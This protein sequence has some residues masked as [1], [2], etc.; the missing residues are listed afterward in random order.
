MKRVLIAGIVFLFS[1][2]SSPATDC[3][4][5]W[6]DFPKVKPSTPGAQTQVDVCLSNNFGSHQGLMQDATE[7]AVAQWN[8]TQQGGMHAP[9]S[10][11]LSSGNC[12]I[13][14]L[15][16]LMPTGLDGIG[17]ANLESDLI[18]ITGGVLDDIANANIDEE[19]KTGHTASLVAHELGHFLG[20][21]NLVDDPNCAQIISVMA[22]LAYWTS[23]PEVVG[24]F[25]VGQAN[26]AFSQTQDSD[27]AKSYTDGDQGTQGACQEDPCGSIECSEFDESCIDLELDVIV[28]EAA[29][30]PWF[31][32]YARYLVTD[33]YSCSGS[34]CTYLYTQF[35][36]MGIVCY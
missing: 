23:V 6:K 21:A 31:G 24:A 12:D 15:Q 32:C 11:N 10:F 26:K 35:E 16:G 25:D 22:F 28:E 30:Y 33:Y 7:S 9:Y 36:F 20:L 8:T 18:R 19:D 13:S 5:C 14:I 2:F 17:Y 4:P 34:G 1:V 29:P 3:P 27:C